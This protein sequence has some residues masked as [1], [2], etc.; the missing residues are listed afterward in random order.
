MEEGEGEE[1]E[2][3]EEGQVEE[4][5]GRSDEERGGTSHVEPMVSRTIVSP[6]H[7]K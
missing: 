7:R 2:M 4:G 6:A 1:G 3:E 5:E